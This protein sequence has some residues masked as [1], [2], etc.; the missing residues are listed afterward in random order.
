MRLNFAQEGRHVAAA[1]VHLTSSGYF[2]S[3]Q[4]QDQRQHRQQVLQHFNDDAS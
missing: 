4:K 1:D 3:N 2:N